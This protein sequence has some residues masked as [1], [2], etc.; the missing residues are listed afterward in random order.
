MELQNVID[1]I[2]FGEVS[3]AQEDLNGFLVIAE[4]LKLKGLI[5][6]TT[7]TKYEEKQT[8]Q[9]VPSPAPADMYAQ[10]I[11]T[12]PFENSLTA[13]DEVAEHFE[14]GIKEEFNDMSENVEYSNDMG[15][16]FEYSNNEYETVI[17]SMIE[18]V[19]KLWHCKVC[20]KEYTI[21]NKTNIKKHVENN[22]ARGFIH[23]CGV[24][25]KTFSTKSTLLYHKSSCKRDVATLTCV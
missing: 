6:T 2:Y 12:G 11:S 10:Q 5:N 15:E 18:K 17:L 7:S 8:F 4:D 24:C 22:H 9:N 20:G 25:G 3:I 1:Y 19:N 21:K 23:T 16:N 13:L 14:E